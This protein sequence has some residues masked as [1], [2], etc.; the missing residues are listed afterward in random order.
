MKIL[1]RLHMMND[2]IVLKEEVLLAQEMRAYIMQDMLLEGI[3][4]SLLVLD[5]SNL[6]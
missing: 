2:M 5:I 3:S 6:K 1:Q 4:I